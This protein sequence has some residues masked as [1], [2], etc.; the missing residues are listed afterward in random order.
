MAV[1]PPGCRGI[2]GQ[3][4]TA[5]AGLLKPGQ[6]E[7]RPCSMRPADRLRVREWLTPEGC[8]HGARESTGV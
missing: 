6:K 4:K 7:G 2:G 8:R 5:V 1:L 3:A